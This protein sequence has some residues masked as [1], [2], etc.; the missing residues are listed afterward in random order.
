MLK[1]T[2]SLVLKKMNSL[3]KI[4]IKEIKKIYSLFVNFASLPKRYT[5]NCTCCDAYSGY[6]SS[7]LFVHSLHLPKIGNIVALETI[8]IMV[9]TITMVSPDVKNSFSCCL[10]T[11]QDLPPLK[12]EGVGPIHSLSPSLPLSHSLYHT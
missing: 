9:I 2:Y 3:N 12:R 10:S 5:Y 11:T 7:F 6:D 8:S 4:I 1:F